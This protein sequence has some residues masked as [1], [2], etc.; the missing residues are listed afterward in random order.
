MKKVLE[1]L[2]KHS[3][4]LCQGPQ[5]CEADRRQCQARREGKGKE[6]RQEGCQEGRRGCR[7]S[8]TRGSQG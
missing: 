8:R 1:F 4:K 2:V 3:G 7:S 6:G 5:G